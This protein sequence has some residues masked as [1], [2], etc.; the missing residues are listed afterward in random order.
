[1]VLQKLSPLITSRDPGLIPAALE[2]MCT[3]QRAL[4]A[5][6]VNGNWEPSTDAS[7]SVGSPWT[8]RS[9]PP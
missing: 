2:Q 3:P 9:A 1:V 5:T 4:M 7:L 8:G 6:Y